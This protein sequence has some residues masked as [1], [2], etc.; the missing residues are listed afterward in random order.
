MRWGVSA[1]PGGQVPLASPATGEAVWAA[2][3]GRG[4]RPGK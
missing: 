2:I 3:Q 1:P 4:D